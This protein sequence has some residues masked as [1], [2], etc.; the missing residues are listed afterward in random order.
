MNKSDFLFK[1]PAFIKFLILINICCLILFTNCHGDR[2]KSNKNLTKDELSG[3]VIIFH[4][5]S[6]SVP[7]NE[8]TA[9]FSKI[10][11]K[12]KFLIEP[13][14]SIECAR[15]ITE[16]KRPCDIIISA[17]YKV[18]DKLLIPEYTDWSI[19][20]ASNELSIVFTDKSKYADKIN[21]INWPEILLKK[22]VFFGRS[23][24][25][26]DPC[27]YRS[28]I[29][30]QLAEKYYKIKGLEKQLLAK[31]HNFIRPKETDLIALLESNAV[32]YIFLYRSVAEQH[33]LNYI[34]LP[35]SINLKKIEYA[36]YYKTANV[37]IKGK[38][39]GEKIIQTGEPMVYGITILK[40]A[41]N[42]KAAE[43]FVEFL[44]DKETGMKIIEKNGQPS[45]IPSKTESFD[46][47]PAALK[48]YATK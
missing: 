31:D 19:K 4:A 1:H 41:P 39:P 15:K 40:N 27:G 7:V 22:D 28:V 24:P 42:S 29:S 20:F 36:D 11:P 38:K 9:A 16:L 47:T 48:K 13:A 23:D 45:V 46:K 8:I 2:S 33:N 32:D 17:D 3:D 37:E 21:S 34:L 26:N 18:I 10:H 43:A 30:I 44:L 25:D 12:V 5:G 35:D 14:G 6:L